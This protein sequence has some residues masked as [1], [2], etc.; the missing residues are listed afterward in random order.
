MLVV[1][2]TILFF[3]PKRVH[4]SRTPRDPNMSDPS[5]FQLYNDI[6][7]LAMDECRDHIAEMLSSRPHWLLLYILLELKLICNFYIAIGLTSFPI[8]P[9]KSENLK[10]RIQTTKVGGGRDWIVTTPKIESIEMCFL[11]CFI[12]QLLYSLKVNLK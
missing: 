11:R 2:S 12:F 3:C 7:Q 1:L 9:F 8:P 6:N 4:Q 5:N 10:F